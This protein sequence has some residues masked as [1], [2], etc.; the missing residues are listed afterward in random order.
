MNYNIDNKLSLKQKI[1]G[2]ILLVLGLIL[3]AYGFNA[4]VFSYASI[5][6][7]RFIL[8]SLFVFSLA[9]AL[10]VKKVNTRGFG[11]V[12]ILYLLVDL[13]FS[14]SSVGKGNMLVIFN[15]ISLNDT[16]PSL[17]LICMTLYF[18]FF[19]KKK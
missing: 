13:I 18:M 14:Q 16:L 5:S 8:G 7:Y 19:K 3:F 9:I 2:L 17:V 1:F 6:A 12:M 11:A 10:F 4:I 15:N